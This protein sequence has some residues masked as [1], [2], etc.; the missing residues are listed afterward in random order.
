MMVVERLT[1]AEIQLRCRREVPLPHETT[2]RIKKLCVLPRSIVVPL[3]P[4]KSL[5]PVS[6]AR[7]A[8]FLAQAASECAGV[9]VLRSPVGATSSQPPSI[10]FCIGP[11]PPAGPSSVAFR[12]RARA[13]APSS[14][15]EQG[16][17]DKGT[18]TL[19]TIGPTLTQSLAVKPR[20]FEAMH[21]QARRVPLIRSPE[22][23]F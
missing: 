9:A 3:S 6:P 22:A 8:N 21:F 15:S 17:S 2:L 12:K 20:H 10:Q 16:T 11:R 13:T 14:P 1:A 23:S 5:L 19:V 7:F 4:D 18:K